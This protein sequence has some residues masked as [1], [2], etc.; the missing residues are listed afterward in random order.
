M[1]TYDHRM[2]KIYLIRHGQS[3]ANLTGKFQGQRYD[4]DLTNQGRLSA[5]KIAATFLT[6][7]ISAI[8]S[9]PLKR[10]IQTAEIISGTLNIPVSKDDRL[11]ET[12]H[13]DWSS[14][15]DA[16]INARWPEEYA[17]WKI[18]PS[19]T[20]FPNGENF[21]GQTAPRVI[22]WWTDLDKAKNTVVVTHENVI[23]IIATYLAGQ[24]LDHIWSHRLDNCSVI[25]YSL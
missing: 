6:E 5:Q 2:T 20:Q 25:E 7:N 15:N 12:D 17:L 19:Q 16:E 11:K 21:A 3:V 4:T 14:L 23:Q 1:T 24:D 22:S 9:S 13:G 10:A 18:H 8:F